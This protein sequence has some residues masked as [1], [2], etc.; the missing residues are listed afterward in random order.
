MVQVLDGTNNENGW[1]KSKLGANAILGVSMAVCR[2][3]ASAHGLPLYAYVAKLAGR[4]FSTGP[5]HLPV[6]FF[7]VINGGEH[8]GN[9]LAFQEFMI[10][11]IGASNFT[12]AMKMG[13]EVYHNSPR[14]TTT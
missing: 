10:A 1:A 3:G 2:A 5:F 12:E 6:P 11:P 13:S 14:S 7:N 9:G 8:A 4:S